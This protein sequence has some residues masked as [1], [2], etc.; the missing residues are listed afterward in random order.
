[1]QSIATL[2]DNLANLSPNDQR[3]A[4]SL[5]SAKRLSEKQAY[6]VNVLAERATKPQPPRQEIKVASDLSGITSLF[7]KASAKLKRPAIVLSTPETGAIRLSVAG[8]KSREPGTVNVTTLGS[9]EERVWLGRIHKDGRFEVSR[10][11]EAQAPAVGKLLARFACD[12]AAVAA[13]HGRTTG[14]CCFCN[15]P[16]T[17]ARSIEVGY[18]PVCAANYGLP[19]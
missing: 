4:F 6:W 2:R 11:A 8:D 16:L 5:L 9:F 19:H 10:K 17:D 15:R 1:M 7:D 14:A 13:E 12:P 3:F 18:G